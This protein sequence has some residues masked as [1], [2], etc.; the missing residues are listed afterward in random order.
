MVDD[1]LILNIEKGK[2][3]AGLAL[4]AALIWRGGKLEQTLINTVERIEKMEVRF[5]K[6]ESKIDN[7]RV[8]PSKPIS[9]T[10]FTESKRMDACLL[11]EEERL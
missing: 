4:A 6:I 8:L 10:L 1:K 2:I 3:F 11:N 7:L 9:N 5:D